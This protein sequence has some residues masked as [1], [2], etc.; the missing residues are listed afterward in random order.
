MSTQEEKQAILNLLTEYDNALNSANIALIPS[1]Y[2]EDGLF[3]PDGMQ[4]LSRNDL[5]K[6]NHESYLKKVQF[7]IDFTIAD[8]IIDGRYAFV[9]AIAKANSR[10]LET[11]KVSAKTSRDLFILR[12]D[13]DKWKIFRYI[14]NNVKEQQN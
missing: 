9:Q 4:E 6:K 3:M 7:R 8:I 2:A 12:K 11:D 5:Q 10:N 1:F 13:Q 14:F